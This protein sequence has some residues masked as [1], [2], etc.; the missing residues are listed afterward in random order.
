MG[1][2]GWVKLII[3]LPSII[4]LLVKIINFIKNFNEK[5]FSEIAALAKEI[6]D[7]I[8][9]FIGK[10][11]KKKAKLV[12]NQLHNEL[13][14]LDRDTKLGKVKVGARPKPLIELRDRIF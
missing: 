13:R 9:K 3:S 4:P 12:A 2:W 6:Y 5:G 11:E 7:L 1:F 8:I 10:K 14:I